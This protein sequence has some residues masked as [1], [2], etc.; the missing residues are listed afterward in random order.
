MMESTATWMEERVATDVNDNRQ[1]LPY[2]QLYAPYVPLDMFNLGSFHQYGNWIFW[3][4]LTNRFGT[5][6]VNKA[7]NQAGSLRRDGGKYSVQALRKLLRRKGG[8]TR[9]YAD[10]A[11]GNLV[12]SH[13]YGEGLSYPQPKVKRS[14]ALSRR[15]RVA[16]F[17][18]RISHLASRSYRVRPGR[19]LSGRRWHLALRVSAPP[20]RTSPAA[21]VTIHRVN[22]RVQHKRVR[23]DRRG[24][25]RRVVTFNRAKVASVSI[26]LVNASTRFRCHRRTYL[27][28]GGK[29]LDDKL[30]FRVRA[31]VLR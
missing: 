6:F 29:P 22:G 9:V 2:S 26:T 16:T 27:A 14:L 17:S 13:N 1:Y 5:T 21:V 24:E 11:A 3:E 18:K 25:G 30:R 12:P 7:W 15:K 20:R 28:C 8:F 31:R 4:H 23:L 19:G 10:F